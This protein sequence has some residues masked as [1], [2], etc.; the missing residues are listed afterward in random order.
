VRERLSESLGDIRVTCCGANKTVGV[1]VAGW[2]LVR[3]GYV[4]KLEIRHGFVVSVTLLVLVKWS[5]AVAS[6]SGQFSVLASVRIPPDLLQFIVPMLRSGSGD[7]FA[8]R[9]HGR[10]RVR[11]EHPIS[12]SLSRTK[13]DCEACTVVLV[14][15][16][17]SSF[18]LKPTSLI[19]T[20]SP[21]SLLLWEVNRVLRGDRDPAPDVLVVPVHCRIRAESVSPR[22]EK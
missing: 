13:A 21:L 9:F 6:G 7:G 16:Q 18:V 4:F 20:S 19:E 17:A 11:L 8:S 14:P 22:R 10:V 15:S 2:T 5:Q 1:W 12:K 3:V